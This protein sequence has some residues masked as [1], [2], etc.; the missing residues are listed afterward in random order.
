M[1][2]SG[3]IGKKLGMTSVF[4]DF[5]RSIPVTV[6]EIEPCV[7]TQIKTQEKDGYR[8]VQIAAFDKRQKS[9]TKALLGHFEKAGAEPK[10]YV[11]E[12]RD[13]IPEGFDLG[14]ELSAADVFNAGDI[15]DVVGISRSEERRVG[16]EWQL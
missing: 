9:T 14:D 5:G 7:I 8:A 6:V 10:R 2:M 11:T 15:V 13:F 16:K 3:L 4:D 1:T 12:F